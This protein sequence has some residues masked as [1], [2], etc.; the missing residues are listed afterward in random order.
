[1]AL[2]IDFDFFFRFRDYEK[3]F[4][5]FMID[6]VKV[7]NFALDKNKV[8]AFMYDTYCVWIFL[9]FYTKPQKS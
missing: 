8:G 6:M 4:N 7:Y 9:P 1:M 2:A 5:G 3:S